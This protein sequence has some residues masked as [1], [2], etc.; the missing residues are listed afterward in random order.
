MR[1]P[2]RS[3]RSAP[4]ASSIT[5][6]SPDTAAFA[7]PTTT[8]TA[9]PVLA[10]WTASP[11]PRS[12]CMLR[13]ILLSASFRTRARNSSPTHTLRL[14][15]RVMEVTALI[16]PAIRGTISTGLRLPSFV[17]C[18]QSP[19]SRME[20]DWEFEVGG[21]GPVIE[22]CWAGFVDLRRMPERACDLP[23]SALLPGLAMVLQRLNSEA[24]PF[25][26]S[27]C[28]FWPMLEAGEFAP[29]ELDAPPGCAA[30]AMSC[31]IDLLS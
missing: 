9:P 24:S 12:S 30:H 2:P 4:F 26:T 27:K 20:A 8:I 13:T 5:R 17:L 22:A 31:Y 19:G 29:D 6:S 21:D 28:D 25:W 11:F 10:W 15:K 16:F 1:P 3:V 14:L 23:E 7:T 18:S